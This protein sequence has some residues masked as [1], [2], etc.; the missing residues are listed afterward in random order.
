MNLTERHRAY[1]RSNLLLTL[2]LLLI[3]FGVTFVAG[4]FANELN[5][6]QFLGF[7]LGFYIFAQGA[8]ITYLIIVGVYV[9]VMNRLDRRYRVKQRH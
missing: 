4:Y 3:W 1:W 8:L 6:V 7:P 9:L 5:S 2:L